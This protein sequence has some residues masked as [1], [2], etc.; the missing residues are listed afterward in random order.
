MANIYTMDITK[1]TLGNLQCSPKLTSHLRALG[2]NKPNDIMDA[3]IQNPDIIPIIAKDKG[4]NNT[5]RYLIRCFDS[6]YRVGAIETLLVMYK[7]NG[8]LLLTQLVKYKCE[9]DGI[10][11]RICHLLFRDYSMSDKFSE[12]D[13]AIYLKMFMG[14]TYKYIANRLWYTDSVIRGMIQGKIMTLTSEDNL[15]YVWGYNKIYLDFNEDVSC[16]LRN[17]PVTGLGASNRLSNIL[18]RNNMF[19]AFD[20]CKVYMSFGIEKF[21][22]L[23]GF[24]NGLCNELA[25]IICPIVLKYNLQPTQFRYVKINNNTV[26]ISGYINI[27][28]AMNKKYNT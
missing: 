22:E 6:S 12:V 17:I 20:V 26:D 14:R 4:F 24:G 8:E 2:V 7:D 19:T 11:N 1:I 21:R 16:T 27:S 25:V 13:I 3:I 10:S 15:Y 28:K 18:Q 23:K 5:V 9:I